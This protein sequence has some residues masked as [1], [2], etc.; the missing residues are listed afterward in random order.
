MALNDALLSLN[1]KNRKLKIGN[2]NSSL[3]PLVGRAFGTI[4]QMDTAPDDRPCPYPAQ[5]N[6]NNAED[7]RYG[8]G[9]DEL[10]D[11]VN[12]NSADKVRDGAVNVESRD[13]H[14]LVDNNTH[15]V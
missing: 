2:T 3:Q 8:H 11:K 14:A 4:F 9:N 6:V 1:A 10:R 5:V 15:K 7:L 13:N 12:I